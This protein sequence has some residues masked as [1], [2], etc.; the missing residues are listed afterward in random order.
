MNFPEKI[1]KAL[2]ELRQTRT[3]VTASNLE[4]HKKELDKIIQNMGKALKEYWEGYYG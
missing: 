2:F 1:E 3:T 4:A